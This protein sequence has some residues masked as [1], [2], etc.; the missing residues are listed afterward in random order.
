V[1]TF[2]FTVGT[3]VFLAFAFA[4][5]FAFFAAATFLAAAFARARAVAFVLGARFHFL[6]VEY[7]PRLFVFDDGRLH[8]ES[9]FLAR[10]R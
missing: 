3:A 5:A 2:L 9:R 4:F 8:H 7:D 6:V 1:G 10:A